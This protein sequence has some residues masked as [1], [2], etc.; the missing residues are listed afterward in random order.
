MFDNELRISV[1]IYGGDRIPSWCVEALFGAF[2][3]HGDTPSSLDG[4]VHGK[5]EN[6]M[7]DLGIR[8]FQETS[9]WVILTLSACGFT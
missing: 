9:I 3:S 8:L 4:L 2:H 5:S 7:D 1:D 6:Q